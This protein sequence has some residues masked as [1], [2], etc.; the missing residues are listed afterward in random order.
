[1]EINKTDTSEAVMQLRYLQNVYSQ[2]YEIVENEIANYSMALN[3]LSNSKLMLDN[4]KK[5][6]N[7]NTLINCDGGTYIEASIK[8]INKVITYIGAGYL[9][10]KNVEEA[11][12]FVSESSKKNEDVIKKLVTEKQRLQNELVDISY[13]LSLMQ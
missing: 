2:Q 11:T 6:E 7:S 1:M 9:V 10:E 5:L 12:V 13:K 8:S 4:I 3:S